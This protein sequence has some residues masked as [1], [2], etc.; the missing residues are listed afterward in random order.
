MHAGMDPN[1]GHITGSV[2][3]AEVHSLDGSVSMDYLN[4]GI[5][6]DIDIA[7]AHRDVY[8]NFVYNIF[9]RFGDDIGSRYC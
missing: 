2:T 6:V 4:T 3:V 5:T 8:H 9:E 7:S 1:Y